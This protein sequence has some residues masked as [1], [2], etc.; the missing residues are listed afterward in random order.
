MKKGIP[1]VRSTRTGS[2]Y[3]SAKEEGIG[4]GYYNP[5]KARIVL[6]LTLA[7]GEDI[8]KIRSYFE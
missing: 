3:V 6:T 8:K 4:S 2:G 1:V 7:K 5:Q